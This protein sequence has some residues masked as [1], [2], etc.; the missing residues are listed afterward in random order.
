MKVNARK[1][2]GSLRRTWDCELVSF[3]G[4]TLKV[5]GVFAET[6]KHSDLGTIEK[7]TISHETFWLSR[8]YNVFRF[9]NPDGSVRN[10]YLNISMPPTFDGETIEFVDLDIDIV[11][12]PDGRRIVLDEDEFAENLVKYQYPTDLVE[13]VK[14][15][16]Q[17]LLATADLSN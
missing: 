2:D 7:E 16:V 15:T 3:D 6:V 12:W 8:W 1:F 9:E 13:K 17:T 4:E 10:H 14:N 5:R 11:V